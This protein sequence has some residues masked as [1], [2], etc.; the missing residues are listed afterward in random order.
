MDSNSIRTGRDSDQFA[1]RMPAG[2]REYFKKAA[3]VNGR[4]MNAELIAALQLTETLAAIRPGLDRDRLAERILLRLPL[5]ANSSDVAKR[6]YAI[7][8]AMIDE[9]SKTNDE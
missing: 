3:A 6:A 7:A 5:S 1:L 2:M 4:S 8:D 9:R